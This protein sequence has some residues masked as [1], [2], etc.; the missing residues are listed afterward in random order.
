MSVALGISRSGRNIIRTLQKP[1]LVLAL[2][3][4]AAAALGEA[5]PWG[6]ESL[7]MR[8]CLHNILEASQQSRFPV[9]KIRLCSVPSW[10]AGWEVL[11]PVPGVSVFLMIGAS[12]QFQPVLS[13]LEISL[14]FFL[15][16]Y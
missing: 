4:A 1:L 6:R 13:S 7:V 8:V 16:Y 3:A 15:F 12:G 14:V 9:R 10:K 2:P 11:F 5:S